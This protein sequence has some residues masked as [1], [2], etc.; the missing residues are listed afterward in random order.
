MPASSTQSQSV[1]LVCDEFIFLPYL[2]TYFCVISLQLTHITNT[3]SLLHRLCICYMRP[4]ININVV[5]SCMHKV[6]MQYCKTYCNTIAIAYFFSKSIAISIVIL[7]PSSIA[8]VIA[9]RFTS[10]ANNFGGVERGGKG[11]YASLALGGMD[12][13][14]RCLFSSVTSVR[15]VKRNWLPE[16]VY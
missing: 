12:A 15:A 3:S 5:L 13:T 6:E 10:I 7:F 16:T 1:I 4:L 11:E 9:I 8:V 2:F 14:V